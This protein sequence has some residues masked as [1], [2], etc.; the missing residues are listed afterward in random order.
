M[1][2]HQVI[3]FV[4]CIAYYSVLEMGPT[5]GIISVCVCVHWVVQIPGIIGLGKLMKSSPSWENTSR[6]HNALLSYQGIG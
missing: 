6:P 1:C 4:Q 3:F 2:K 5:M